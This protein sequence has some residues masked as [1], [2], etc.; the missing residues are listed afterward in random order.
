MAA[1]Q[2]LGIEFFNCRKY[3]NVAILNDFRLYSTRRTNS[4]FPLMRKYIQIIDKDFIN[5]D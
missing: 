2:K 3:F 4:K 5:I 1:S